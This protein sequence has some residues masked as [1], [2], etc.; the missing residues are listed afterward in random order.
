[1]KRRTTTLVRA[2]KKLVK[3]ARSL[4]ANIKIVVDIALKAYIKKNKARG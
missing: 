1:M 3:D 4:G 2:D